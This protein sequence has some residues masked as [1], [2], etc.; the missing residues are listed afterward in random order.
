MNQEIKR[1]KKRA[2]RERIDKTTNQ[3]MINLAWGIL[4]IILLRFVEAGYTSSN[5]ILQ[6]P[7]IMKTFA[8]VFAVVSVGLFVC[9]GK[10]LFD[11]KATFLGYAAFALTLTLGA[12]WIGF[13]P[14]IRNLLGGISPAALNVDSRWWISRGPIVVV[15]TY[16]VLTLVWTAVKIS[17][18]ERGKKI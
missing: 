6:M 7:G 12:V 2:K 9:G 8:C 14:E 4:V 18:I 11:K 10:N 13:Y 3:Y 15:V 5:T 17:M 16:L 1:E